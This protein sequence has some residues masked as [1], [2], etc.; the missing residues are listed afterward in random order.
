MGVN[1][2]EIPDRSK[3][4]QASGDE[5]FINFFIHDLLFSLVTICE[6]D[7]KHESFVFW[8][9]LLSCLRERIVKTTSLS[10]IFLSMIISFAH[11]IQFREDIDSNRFE[12]IAHQSFKA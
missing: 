10:C 8:F 12:E 11:K 3:R 4:W 6:S 9:R 7:R 5:T 1:D 2:P